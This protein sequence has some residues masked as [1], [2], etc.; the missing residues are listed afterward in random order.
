MGAAVVT[1]QQLSGAVDGAM[2]VRGGDDYHHF[3][4]EHAP[5]SDLAPAARVHHAEAVARS[6]KILS[7]GT[8]VERFR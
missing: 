8:G 2:L 3:A 1:K 7:R 5:A 4:P 6:A